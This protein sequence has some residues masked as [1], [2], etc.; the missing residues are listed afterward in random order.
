MLGVFPGLHQLFGEVAA[1]LHQERARPHRHIADLEV[2]DLRRR[3]QLPL[4]L[5]FALSRADVDQRVEG[6][7]HNRFSQAARGIVRPCRAAVAP[8][9]DIDRI[10]GDDADQRRARRAQTMQGY[11]HRLLSGQRG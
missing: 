3:A 4:L 7:L 1:G 10:G 11:C 8:L 6:V 9:R 5:W 2:E